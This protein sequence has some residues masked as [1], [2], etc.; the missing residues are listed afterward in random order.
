MNKMYFATKWIF[1][2]FMWGGL[3]FTI[4]FLISIKSKKDSM[5]TLNVKKFRS[6]MLFLV[7]FVLNATMGFL[8]IPIRTFGQSG[9]AVQFINNLLV[10]V[11]FLFFLLQ[12][13]KSITFEKEK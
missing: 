2:V 12:L 5:A 7:I 9:I 4:K 11:F 8:D 6:A 3:G 1:I 10:G 13:W